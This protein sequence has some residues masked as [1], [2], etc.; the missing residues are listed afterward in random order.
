MSARWF[1]SR[2]SG[3]TAG[4]DADEFK[5]SEVEDAVF[6]A[7]AQFLMYADKLTFKVGEVTEAKLQTLNG[8]WGE[9]YLY[10]TTAEGNNECWKTQTIVNRSCLGK[11][12]YQWPTRK[13]KK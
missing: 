9:S 11:L 8:V 6:R 1:A 12:F 3:L 10:V 2:V 4:V 13:L 5:A 7:R